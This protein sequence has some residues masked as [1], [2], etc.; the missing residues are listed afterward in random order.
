MTSN[1]AIVDR[2]VNELWNAR[3][4]SVADEIFAPRCITH[5]LRSGEPITSAPRDPETLKQHVRD[6]VN[7][8]PDLQFT[9]E[10]TVASEDR[11][12][13]HLT[14][15]GTHNGAWMGVSPT[16]KQISITMIVIHR[17]E[18]GKI[19]E[20]WVLVD[21]LGL[22][23]QLGLVESREEIFSRAQLQN[24]DASGKTDLTVR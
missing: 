14:M 12:A 13:S 15:R 20:D 7:A 5:Q 11:V 22:F 24:P 4:L 17:I 18:A 9:I 8:F 6:W 2:F 1:E 23:Q 21:S 10:Q 19:V 3:E 16:G